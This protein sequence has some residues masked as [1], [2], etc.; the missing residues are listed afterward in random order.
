M[1]QELQQGCLADV[2]TALVLPKH[3]RDHFLLQ[4]KDMAGQERE[5]P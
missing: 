3:K 2:L 1:L 4:S 5:Q